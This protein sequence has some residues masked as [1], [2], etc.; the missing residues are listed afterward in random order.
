MTEK[1]GIEMLEE[2]LDYVKTLEK[3]LSI[4]DNNI[5][6]IANSANLADMIDKIGGTKLD[7]WAKATKP[8]LPKI[9]KKSGFK[10]FGF[11]SV[12]AS[13]V[14]R[15]TALANKTERS[16][17]NGIMV[18][19]RLKIKKNGKIVPLC[20]VKVK[21]YDTSDNLVKNTITNRAGCWMAQLISGKYVALFTGDLD[22][23]QLLPQNKNFEVPSTLESGQTKFE[24]V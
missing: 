13:K 15:D 9:E 4:M 7:N 3:R 20:G 2:I 16:Q 8:G 12:D 24:V 10:N 5:K 14:V 17:T 6:A 1:S 18:E 11:E 22:G 21:I 23:K 19:G